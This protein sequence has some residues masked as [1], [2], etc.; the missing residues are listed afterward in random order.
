MMMTWLNNPYAADLR[1]AVADGMLGPISM[2]RVRNAHRGPYL[3]GSEDH[4]RKDAANVGGGCFIQL[5]VHAMNLALH[6]VDRP[7]EAVLGMA[8]N[9]HCR[10]SLEVGLRD[11]AVV[12]ALYQSARTGQTV[13]LRDVLS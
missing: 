12:E 11:L 7:V 13:D 5:A 9:L 4:W 8:G 3:Q 10:H 2:V 6:I 1:R